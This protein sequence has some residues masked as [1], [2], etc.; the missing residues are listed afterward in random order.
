MLSSFLLVFYIC[1]KNFLLLLKMEVKGCGQFEWGMRKAP[2]CPAPTPGL[3]TQLGAVMFWVC[4]SHEVCLLPELCVF[5][6]FSRE[7]DL[8]RLEQNPRDG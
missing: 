4:R 5:S 2:A 1:F 7:E 8:R 6:L 3:R